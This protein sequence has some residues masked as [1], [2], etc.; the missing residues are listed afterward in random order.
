MWSIDY[1]EYGNPRAGTYLGGGVGQTTASSGGTTF[2]P[3]AG[4]GAGAGSGPAPGAGVGA[5]GAASGGNTA[6]TPTTGGG[7]AGDVPPQPPTYSPPPQ[8]QVEQ[9]VNT[10]V[11]YVAPSEGYQ[12]GDY[13]PPSNVVN[14]RTVM[15]VPEYGYEPVGDTGMVTDTHDYSDVYGPTV[16]AYLM[17]TAQWD[18]NDP[19]KAAV[20]ANPATDVPEEVFQSD[21]GW[22]NQFTTGPIP[23]EDFHAAASNTTLLT[24]Y[25]NY[26][27]AQAQEMDRVRQEHFDKGEYYDYKTGKW[28]TT[29]EYWAS[30]ATPGLW[31]GPA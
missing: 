20:V 10:P 30:K 18:P 26:T 3:G 14:G 31:G 12:Y 7:G 15:T 4:A 23:Y 9:P 21:Y 28:G 8:P 22:T 17:N 13:I 6:P 19:F 2:A 29:D 11:N 5:G 25:G 1:D 16:H 27:P 24:P